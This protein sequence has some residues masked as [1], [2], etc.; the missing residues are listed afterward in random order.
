MQKRPPSARTVPFF[1][2][3]L[4]E[5]LEL[6]YD[7]VKAVIFHVYGE[8]RIAAGDGNVNEMELSGLGTFIISA[9]RLCSLISK[10]RKTAFTNTPQDLAALEQKLDGFVRKGKKMGVRTQEW[11]QELLSS[12]GGNQERPENGEGKSTGGPDGGDSEA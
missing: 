1:G 3:I 12:I 8:S 7:L 6:D 2:K 11:A 9:K 10:V 4:A 5:K